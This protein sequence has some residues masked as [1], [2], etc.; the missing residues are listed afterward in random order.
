[1]N[2]NSTLEVGKHSISWILDTGAIDHITYH[3]DSLTTHKTIKPIHVTLPNG[4]NIVASLCGSITF[5]PSLIIHNVL[6]IPTFNVN[7]IYVIKLIN[8]LN[9]HLS[10]FANT[11]HIL[12][13]TYKSSIGIAN[14]HKGLYIL[15]SFRHASICNFVDSNSYEIWISMLGH[16]SDI[17]LKAIFR[18]FSFHSLKD[19]LAPCDSC[20]NAK[21]KKTFFSL[22]Q[23]SYYCFF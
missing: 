19:Y 10:F 6:Y 15:E 16:I 22:K 4:T 20:H 9:C 12:Q 21:Q 7:H 8:D 23:Y 2:T 3:L 17:G 11:C 5:T 18:I 13:N 1:M 14:M